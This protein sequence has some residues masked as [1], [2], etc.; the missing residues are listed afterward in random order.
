MRLIRSTYVLQALCALVGVLAVAAAAFA[1]HHGNYGFAAINL[2][3]FLANVVLFFVQ[4][5]ARARLRKIQ[6]QRASFG[7]Y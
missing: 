2:G 7:F 5:A 3:L 6:T 1:F 4:R